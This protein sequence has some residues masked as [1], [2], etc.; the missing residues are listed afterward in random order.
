MHSSGFR[1]Q[2][3][4]GAQTVTSVSVSPAERALSGDE[5]HVFGAVVGEGRLYR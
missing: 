5:D 2:G 1:V 4:V 3:E